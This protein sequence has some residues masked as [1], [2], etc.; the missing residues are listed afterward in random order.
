MKYS[1][2]FRHQHANGRSTWHLEWCTKYRYK[3]FSRE[4]NKNLC[5]IA[6]MEAAKIARVEILEMEVQPEHVHLVAE[7]PLTK[8]PTKIVG[9]LKSVSARILFSQIP[10]LRFRYPK[11]TL[12]SKGKFAMSVG[13][14]TLEKAKEYVRNQET[15]H[16]KVLTY[17]LGILAIAVARVSPQ[18]EG[19]PRGGCQLNTVCNFLVDF[20]PCWK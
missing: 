14:I 13:N 15:H 1:K 2:Y 5:S 9:I 10:K 19:L 3:V 17:F 16:A 4:N 6:L 12:W 18:A 7:L 20:I 8:A 11:G